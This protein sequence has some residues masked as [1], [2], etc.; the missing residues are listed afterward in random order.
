MKAAPGH[1]RRACSC[2]LGRGPGTESAALIL[3]PLA[4]SCG[5]RYSGGFMHL[6]ALNIFC[7]V[8]R[9]QSFSR[10]ALANS[11]SQSAASQAVRQLERRLGAELIDRSRRPWQ[12]TPEGKLFFQGCQE[13]VDRYHE[14]EEAVQRR[15]DPS[16]YTV[17]L[18]S[19]YSVGLHDLSQYVDRFRAAV[20]GAHVDIEY[21][22]PDE[23]P[24]RIQNDQSDVGLLA[25][26]TPGRDLTVVPWR[27]QTMA[28]ACPPAHRFAQRTTAIGP[29]EL[30]GAAFV[31]FDRGLPVRREL[32]RYLRRHGV[33][34]DVV[35]E[36]DTIENIKQAVEDGAGVAI[37]PESTLRREVERQTLVAV[38]LDK[39]DGEAAFVRP[40]SIVHRR[41]RRLNPAVKQFIRLLRLDG[42]GQTGDAPADRP[43]AA[44][45]RYAGAAGA[46]A[47][48]VTGT[49]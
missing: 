26:A 7:D 6:E 39:L 15:Q 9:H 42:A 32:D 13:I 29:R 18:A 3:R 4:I 21:M 38:P 8:V 5:G 23:I 49:P 19:I 28:V 40:L 17:R 44:R 36:F 46:D 20:P 35:A 43:A 37:L 2:G 30:A 47:A 27:Q 31:T 14:L 25:F 12:L 33:D 24:T 22:H 16:G 48:S 34:V 11:V 41:R 1:R 10:G 45:D